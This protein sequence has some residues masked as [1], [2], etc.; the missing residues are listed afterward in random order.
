MA[1]DT[2]VKGSIGKFRGYSPTETGIPRW[3]DVII[4]PLWGSNGEVEQLLAVSRDITEQKQM[5][6]ELLRVQKLESVGILAGGIAHDFNNILTTILGNVSLAK[7]QVTPDDEIFE[8]LNEAETASTRAQTLTRQL[9]TFAKGGA[10]VKETSSIKDVIKESSLFVLRGSKAGCEFSLRE[11][12]WPAEVDVG[13]IGQVIN[14]IVINANQAMPEGG[15]IRVAAENV[16]IDDGQGLPLKPGRYIRISITDHG[17]GIA[18]KH[19]SNIFDPYF[20]TKQEGS[21]LG[22]ATTYSI[23]RKHDGQITVESKLGE[24]TTFH[25]YLPASDKIVPEKEEVRLIKGRG[26][27]LVMDDEVALKKNDRENAAETGL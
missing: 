2:E 21:G 15:I 20:T 5:E 4:A 10:P 23:I 19:L 17:A 27:I 7:N 18:E 6:E 8:L 24:G 22:L 12:L 1:V 3:W 14:N 9:L 16:I 25:I 26:R 13:Q 11:D